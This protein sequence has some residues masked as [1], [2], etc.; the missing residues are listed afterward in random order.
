M[1]KQAKRTSA[2]KR[3]VLSNVKFLGGDWRYGRF[4]LVNPNNRTLSASSIEPYLSLFSVVKALNQ[5]ER[6]RPLGEIAGE[7]PQLVVA[8]T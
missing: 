6:L 7:A 3:E 4:P 5:K 8:R 2:A 1:P